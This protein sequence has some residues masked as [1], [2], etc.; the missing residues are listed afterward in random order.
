MRQKL[1][2]SIQFLKD[3]LALAKETLEVEKKLEQPEDKR[4]KAKDALTELFESVKTPETPIVVENVVND[5]D[6][7]V[8][9]IVRRF[10]NAFKTVTGQNEVRKM[11]RTILWLKYKIKDNEVFEKAYK[12]VEMY[13]TPINGTP[14]MQ[15][16]E[17][18][19]SPSYDSNTV[20]DSSDNQEEQGL[21]MAAD[22]GDYE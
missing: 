7:Q 13:Y 17:E 1:I 18:P 8:V 21:W 9:S 19:L 6:T 16:K 12:Y 3:L 14:N 2:D 10:S 15:A 20:H 4:K 5:I 11:L 22:T